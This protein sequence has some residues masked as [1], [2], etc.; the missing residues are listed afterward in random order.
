MTLDSYARAF[1]QRVAHY[2]GMW[3]L[4]LR[5]DVRCRTEYWPAERRRQTYFM[6]N[7]AKLAP[8][9]LPVNLAMPWD[10]V[11]RASAADGAFWDAEFKDV[12]VRS[13]LALRAPDAIVDELPA[14]RPKTKGDGKGLEIVEY[15]P[16]AAGKGT[17]KDNNQQICYAYNQGNCKGNRC[18]FGRRHACLSCGKMG[19]PA[20]TCWQTTPEAKRAPG[21]GK[22]KKRRQQGGSGSRWQ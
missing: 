10:P 2:P 11:I 13:A 21:A 6:D 14:K 22:K 17:P 7:A 12:A 3:H 5:A 18:P 19:H 15:V 1:K 8:L 4:A 20:S 9:K 16:H